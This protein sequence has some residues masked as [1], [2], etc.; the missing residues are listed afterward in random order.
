MSPRHI[1]ERT[2]PRAT[3]VAHFA[4]FFGGIALVILLLL[5]L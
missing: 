1:V 3:T 2:R 5:L 4:Y